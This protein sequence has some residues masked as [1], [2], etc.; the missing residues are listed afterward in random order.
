[1]KSIT[2][3]SLCASL[4]LLVATSSYGADIN[5]S[6][7]A[8]I[9]AGTTTSSSEAYDGYTSDFDFNQGSLFALQTSSDLG[10]GLSVTAQLI[11]RGN[12]DWDPSFEWA[13]LG[14]EVNDNLKIL[15]GRQRAPFF[16]YSD[17]LDVSYAYH[18][19]APPSGAY[20]LAF[21][22]FDGL[23]AIYTTQLGEFDSTFHAILGRNQDEIAL[24][25]S[26][27]GGTVTPDFKN[28]VGAAWTLNRDWL[29][30][31]SAFFSAKMTLPIAA[32]NPLVNG[33]TGAGF[34]DLGESLKAEDDAVWFGELGF[35]VDYND[36][37]IVGEYTRL[38]LDD[39]GLSNDDS[40]YISVGKRFD[41]LTVHVTFGA[42]D[43]ELENLLAN[44]PSNVPA[45]APL[46][47]GTQSIINR[48]KRDDRYLTAGVKWDFHDAASL[49][50]EVT[51]F[52]DKLID[53]NDAT[54]LKVALVTVF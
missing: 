5:F 6:G 24:P 8:T 14:Y 37:I 21:D 41:N 4:P 33:W 35:Q 18:W 49:K 22:S 52:E 9:A 29:T 3:K 11:A 42:D 16:M 48:E 47:V 2:L 34:A 46:Y 19:I 7:F 26:V 23:G 30:L 39:T 51:Q 44:V 53:T 43:D 36:F 32:F 54:L 38:N 31:R 15:A 45:I 10:G 13:F 25:D 28:V 27:G 17:F 12:D 50:F 40:Y 20:N 1:M